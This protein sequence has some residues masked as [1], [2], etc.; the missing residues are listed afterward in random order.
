MVNSE[1]ERFEIVFDPVAKSAIL[2]RGQKFDFLAGP[3]K[4][5]TEARRATMEMSGKPVETQSRRRAVT[6]RKTS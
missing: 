2:L 6:G 1:A 4:D 5:Y 3:F